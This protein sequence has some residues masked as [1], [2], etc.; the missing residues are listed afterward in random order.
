ME[1][2]V[3]LSTDWK[4]ALAE[5]VSHTRSHLMIASPYVTGEGVAF[6]M[7][8][9]SPTLHSITFVTD[10]SPTN[11]CD[12]ATDPNAL[13]VLMAGVPSV[14]VRHLPRLHAKVYVGDA[15]CAIIT[16]ANLTIGGLQRNYEYGVKVLDP[17][18]AASVFR[19]ISKYSELG[20]FVARENLQ[21]Y[22]DLANRLRATYRRERQSASRALRVEFETHLAEAQD[23][24]LRLRLAEG[25]M[26]TVFAKT[27][28]Y[29]LGAHGP[30]TTEQLHPRIKSIH[31]DLCDNGVDRVIDGKSYG[32]K[33]K[34]AVRSAQQQLKRQGLVILDDDRWRL[35]A[36]I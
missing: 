13:G 17:A 12:G 15:R 2:C 20:A 34:H 10:L 5:L 25:P 26:H 6:L 31:P 36:P 22:C 1:E 7:D 4:S 32:K 9:R 29:L 28:Q 35:T 8:N 16:S 11:V 3:L 14:T 27:I 30:L 23:E 24:L 18:V 33:W 21:V 19:D